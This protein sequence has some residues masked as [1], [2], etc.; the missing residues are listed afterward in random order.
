M[1]KKTILWIAAGALVLA[2]LLG[3]LP[4]VSQLVF[5]RSVQATLLAWQFHKDRYTTEEA[6]EDYLD[7]KRLENSAPYLLPDSVSFTVPKFY[8]LHD[9]MQVFALPGGGDRK[10]TIVY[11]PG[12]S[13]IDQPTE[14]HWRFLN[15]LAEDTGARVYVPIY[16]KL[17]EHDAEDAYAAVTD[18]YADMTRHST[19]GEI[20]FMGDSAGG[21]MALSFAMQL[22]DT[23]LPQPD[24]LILLSPWVDVT[25]TNSAIPA[26]EKKDPVLDAEMLRRLGVLW[27][28]D[29]DTA[30]PVV[31]PLYGDLTG[32]GKI[33]FFTTDGELLYPDHVE[34]E[35]ALTSAGADHEMHLRPNLFHCWPL[36]AYM[37][38]P[39]SHEAYADIVRIIQE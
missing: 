29:L 10:L 30:D 18:W 34:L 17:P 35:R 3:G 7:V 23:E 24:K 12:G 15:D 37:D 2:L 16:P 14:T 27:A 28:D 6:F 31:S 32:L 33:H 4:L 38:I 26:H 11:F 8:S 25:M 22:R 21:G 19:G 5:H 36:F 9:G 1:K 39:E 13:Y 20:V